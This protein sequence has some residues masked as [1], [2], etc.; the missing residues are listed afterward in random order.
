MKTALPARTE[1]Y[2]EAEVSAAIASVH[3]AFE[4]VASAFVDARQVA[5]AGTAGLCFIADN[6]VHGGLVVGDAHAWTPSEAHSWL[7][8]DTVT[9]SRDATQIDS[10]NGA[11][12]MGHPLTSLTW[13]ANNLSMVNAARGL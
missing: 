5:P 10:G 13:L 4:I 1:P 7:T 8:S 9:L 3:A 6:G 2:S 12:A 11:N